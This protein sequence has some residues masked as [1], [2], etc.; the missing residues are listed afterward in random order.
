MTKPKSTRT[1][2]VVEVVVE[3]DRKVTKKAVGGWVS[4]GLRVNEPLIRVGFEGEILTRIPN[5]R[6]RKVDLD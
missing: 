5:A 3:T 6:V 2:Y 4:H 1:K